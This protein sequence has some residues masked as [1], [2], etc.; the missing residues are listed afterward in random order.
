MADVMATVTIAGATISP[1]RITDTE[2]EPFA[3]GGAA[4]VFRARYD[5]ESIVIKRIRNSAGL[6]NIIKDFHNE[7][8]TLSKL[9]HTRI[10]RFYGILK[11]SD[12]CISLVLEDMT[13]GSLMGYYTKNPKPS[14]ADRIQVALDIAY[15][16]NYL[17]EQSPPVIHRDLKSLNVLLSHEKGRI[18]AKV[19]DFGSAMLQLST[20]SQTSS[21]A[22][23]L[24]GTTLYYRAPELNG[25]I[26]KFTTA[27]DVYAFGV[28]LSEIASWA[29]PY[30]YPWS[31]L[32]SHM[33][34]I[35]MAQGKPIPFDLDECDMP[36]AFKGLILDCSGERETRPSIG[37]IIDVLRMITASQYLPSPQE[38]SIKLS[39]T[40][41]GMPPSSSLS[42][43]ASSISAYPI[44]ER[45]IEKSMSSNVSAGP[46]EPA[47]PEFEA[48]LRLQPNEKEAAGSSTFSDVST[49]MNEPSSTSFSEYGTHIPV[50]AAAIKSVSS[51]LNE[52]TIS[53]PRW[54]AQTEDFATHSESNLTL[55]EAQLS[56]F[57][58]HKRQAE[59]GNTESQNWLASAYFSGSDGAQRNLETAIK[60]WRLAANQGN[61]AAQLSLGLCY[62]YGNGI[63]KDWKEAVKWYTLSAEQG[64]TIAQANL[65][66]CFENGHGVAQNSVE[67]VKWYRMAAEQGY[68]VAQCSLALCFEN[69]QGVSQDF[70]EALNWYSKAAEEGDA[71]AKANFERCYLKKLNAVLENPMSSNVLKPNEVRSFKIVLVGDGA[72]GKTA[73]LSVQ[74]GIGYPKVQTLFPCSDFNEIQ[75]YSEP[76]LE[77]FSSRLNIHGK[78]VELSI[79][80]TDG[81]EGYDRL[82]PLFYPDTD[83]VIICY[84][85][86]S[87]DS[88]SNVTEK[89]IPEIE[90]YLP[91]CPKM[92]VGT[93]S[94]ERHNQKLVDKLWK[95]YAQ[96]PVSTEQGQKLAAQIGARIFLECSAKTGQGVSEVFESAATLALSSIASPKSKRRSTKRPLN[97]KRSTIKD[98]CKPM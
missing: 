39:E 54:N 42:I 93:K 94:D 88:L 18:C 85:I 92:L 95:N 64:S 90:N 43:F 6:E 2:E 12:R 48:Q 16:V 33:V 76:T 72:C 73:L 31:R 20:A 55:V 61:A 35:F 24:V 97:S 44:S 29:G 81:V 40:S 25:F 59:N 10:V 23:S 53:E 51:Q 11:G 60:W 78:A 7:V 28:V 49:F 4:D 91:E 27:S 13:L 74:S 46:D 17:H 45:S 56:T 52:L 69:G 63:L 21:R 62:Y 50:A 68:A 67:A 70:Q 71:S 26:I 57:E 5:G 98:N 75:V 36:Q 79:W 9:N 41:L 83:V 8:N 89:W 87:P 22:K 77:Q 38:S 32:N 3:S 30:G 47:F 15:G 66:T 80:D 82:R 1:S 84:D 96:K 86:S 19:S 37:R 34:E 65:G 14:V 58:S